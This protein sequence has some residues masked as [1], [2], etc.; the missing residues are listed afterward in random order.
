MGYENRIDLS[1][2]DIELLID[3]VKDKSTFSNENIE[4]I[5]VQPRSSTGSCLMVPS[6]R[7]ELEE[8]G[9]DLRRRS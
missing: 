2:D 4:I 3:A 1:I 7:K 8:D 9:H 6:G 5:K